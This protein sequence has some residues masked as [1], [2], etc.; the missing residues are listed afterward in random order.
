MGGST[1]EL[2]NQL[3]IPIIIIKLHFLRIYG[4]V[5]FQHVP[6]SRGWF[7][8]E[9]FNQPITPHHRRKQ[10]NIKGN[11]S[12]IVQAN[13][14]Y[15][16]IGITQRRN[17]MA[18]VECIIKCMPRNIWYDE[19]Q[20]Y[21]RVSPHL[22]SKLYSQIKSYALIRSLLTHQFVFNFDALLLKL[23]F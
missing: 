5:V 15:L 14:A 8:N 13:G 12:I 23:Y 3:S 7:L 1:N 20:R 17:E 4:D 19:V 9:W 11:I 22:A 2:T 16:C 6:G 21:R 10:F 18:F